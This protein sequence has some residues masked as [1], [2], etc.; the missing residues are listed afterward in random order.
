M[1]GAGVLAAF[2][3]SSGAKAGALQPLAETKGGEEVVCRYCLEEEP[4]EELF[5]PCRCTNPVHTSCLRTW[6][7]GVLLARGCGSAGLHR[8]AQQHPAQCRE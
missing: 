1:S 2:G 6:L 3:S 7:T 5:R 4:R 8:C